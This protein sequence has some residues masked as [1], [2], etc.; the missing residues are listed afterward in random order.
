MEFHGIA[1]VQHCDHS[2]SPSHDKGK[3]G[4]GE[5]ISRSDTCMEPA[6]VLGP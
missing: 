2:W 4:Q 5:D 1:T 6:V 3:E